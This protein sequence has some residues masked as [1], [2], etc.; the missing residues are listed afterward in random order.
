MVL[1]SSIGT[2]KMSWSENELNQLDSL[3]KSVISQIKKGAK[4]TE[5]D[6][7]SFNER[8]YIR[9]LQTTKKEVLVLAGLNP[10]E[11]NDVLK[12]QQNKKKR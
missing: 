9:R 8:L 6:G 4:P 7:L 10:E 3:P 12:W 11:A 1:Q 5:L 2:R